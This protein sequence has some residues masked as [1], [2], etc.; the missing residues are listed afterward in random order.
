MNG[1][2]LVVDNLRKYFPLKGFFFKTE[3]YVRAVDGVSIQI[4]RGE[5]FGLVGESGCG[6]TTLGRCLLR[7]IEPDKGSVFYDG[8]DMMKLRKD[9]LKETRQRIQI[10][11][12]NPLSSL[13]PRMSVRNLVAEPL[14]AY[15]LTEHLDSKIVE[16]LELVGLRREFLWRYPHELSGGQNQRIAIARA[17]A[18]NPN[19]IVLDEPT[20]ALDVS[21]QA[22]ILN[23]LQ[24]LQE[25]LHMSYLL[26]SH[27]LSVVQHI[28]NRM[29]VMYLGK[30]VE[31][32]GSDEIWEKP[33]HPYTEALL[34]AVPIPDP[35]MKSQSKVLT[36][37]VPSPINPPSGCRFRTRCP[38][39]MDKCQREEPQ[40]IY[41]DRQHQVAC[42]LHD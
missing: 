26:I 17:I 42:H 1:S 38:Y 40:M 22:Q 34:S 30:I 10:V 8:V 5:V 18:L 31:M 2:L 41:I 4:G 24:E 6:K 32:G 29:G 20:S 9:Q 15:K 16:L 14:L 33:L 11:F 21:V 36:G 37:E 19:F 13:D 39:V 27:D 3:G 23:L 7:L 35:D 25:R 28:S 12:Q